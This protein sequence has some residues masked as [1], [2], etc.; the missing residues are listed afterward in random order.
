[1]ITKTIAVETTVYER[2][3]RVK[4]PSE[5]FTKMIARVLDAATAPTCASLVREAAAAGGRSDTRADAERIEELV[6]QSRVG[7]NWCLKRPSQS[8]A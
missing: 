7:A 6:R 5:S 1:M 8:A 4:R 2:L 3:A